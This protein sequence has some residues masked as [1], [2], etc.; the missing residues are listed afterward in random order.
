M[1]NESLEKGLPLHLNADWWIFLD[2][3]PIREMHNDAS[4]HICMAKSI[5]MVL[6]LIRRNDDRH[7]PFLN[8]T[9]KNSCR[10]H[11]LGVKENKRLFNSTK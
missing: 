11:K 1:S 6:N 8:H 3:Q 9:W 10:V 4:R 7:I 5:L 2:F